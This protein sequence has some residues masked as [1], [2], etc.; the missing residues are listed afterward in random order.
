MNIRTLVITLLS[1]C[2]LYACSQSR[3]GESMGAMTFE[4]MD[5]NA[6]G[7]ISSA[8]AKADRSIAKNFTDIDSNSD[9]KVNIEEFQA[10]MGKGRLTPPEEMETPE[11]GAA[12]Y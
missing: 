10:H 7:Y 11:P 4:E 5:A 6:D 9:G 3:T 8:E 12:P 2:L 1:S